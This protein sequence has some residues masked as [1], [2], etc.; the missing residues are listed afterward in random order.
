MTNNY[1]YIKTWRAR[2][3]KKI[4][5]YNKK[6]VK[7]NKDILK[8]KAAAKYR[9]LHPKETVE[10]WHKRYAAEHPEIVLPKIDKKAVQVI[11]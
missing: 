3:K 1:E 11:E 9:L 7:E 6:Y 10:E 8:E 2:N 4:E 5:G